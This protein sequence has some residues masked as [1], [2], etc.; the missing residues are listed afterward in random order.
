MRMQSSK[1]LWVSP[2]EYARYL[3]RIPSGLGLPVACLMLCAI[4]FIALSSATQFF[5]QD[6]H[7]FQ[8]QIIWFG[9]ALMAGIGAALIEWNWLRRFVWPI[10]ITTLVLLG[11]VF[12]PGLG[13]EVNGSRRWLDLGLMRLQV[14]EFAKLGMVFV[15]AHYLSVHQRELHT[16]YKGFCIPCAWIGSVC[17]LILLEPDLGTMLLYGMVGYCML[18]M[19]GVRMLYLLPALVL[20]VAGFVGY[21]M[22][23]QVRMARITSFMN[24]ESN[25]AEGAYQLWQSILAFGAGGTSG[26]GIG[27]G[28]QQLAFLPE[29]HTDF[30]F[31]IIGEE[32]GLPITIAVVLLFVAIFVVGMINLRQAPNM[33]EFSL[34][35]GVLLFIVFQSLL[36]FGVV[37]GCLPTTGIS[38]PFISYGGSNLVVM[39]VLCGLMF[40]CFRRWHRSPISRAREL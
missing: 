2:S 23:D 33:F 26:V 22:H 21:L 27:N 12:I 15:L 16:F 11:M 6:T 29:A 10:A 28:R 14:S 25:K 30:I 31:S 34:V 8:K 39:F 19:A 38:L 17:L 5:A 37:T 32:L 35:L 3:A 18:F 20:A 13:V 7:H 9:I 24:I 1:E 40:S 4:G 36:N